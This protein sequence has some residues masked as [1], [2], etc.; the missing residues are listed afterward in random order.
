MSAISPSNEAEIYEVPAAI[1]R[2]ADSPTATESTAG[3]TAGGAASGNLD[4]GAE[5]K[6]ALSEATEH[7][8]GLVPP[9][10]TLRNFVAVNPYLG[11]TQ[12][13]FGEAAS[14]FDRVKHA[15]SLLPLA[16]YL[17]LYEEGRIQELDLNEAMKAGAVALRRPE[18]ETFKADALRER[19]FEGGPAVDRVFTYSELIDRKEG[20]EWS[21]VIIDEI[22]KWCSGRFD[23]GQT[24]WQQPHMQDPIY[25]AWRALA[26]IDGNP[27]VRGLQNF[28]EI[29]RTLPRDA[30]SCIEQITHEIGVPTA[31]LGDYLA[32]SLAS[33]SGWA[34]HLQYRIRQAGMDGRETD[35]CL[36]DLLAI[37]LAFDV[38]VYRDQ[39]KSRNAE[40]WAQAQQASLRPVALESTQD[41]IVLSELEIRHLWQLAL[42]AGYRRALIHQVMAPAQSAGTQKAEPLLQ[43]AFCI[44][45]RSEILRRHLEKGSERVRTIGFAG[46]FGLALESVQNDGS[47]GEARCPALLSPGFSV[48]PK[49]DGDLIVARRRR[50]L[51]QYHS[52]VKQLRLS[53]VVAFPFVETIGQFFGLRLISESLGLTRPGPDSRLFPDAKTGGFS[54]AVATEATVGGELG[55]PLPDRINAAVSILTNM[56]LTQDLAPY[57]LLC[58]HGSTT[59]NNPY[60]SAL[61]C[62]A[63]GGYSGDINARAAANLLNDPA[64]RAALPENGLEVPVSTRFL[65][66]LHDTTTDEIVLYDTEGMTAAELST[67]RQELDRASAA[68]RLER[69]ARLGDAD[70]LG[71]EDLV[72]KRSQDWSEVRPEW[73]LAGNAAFIAAPRE[74]TRGMDLKGR[75]FL[76][77]YNADRDPENSV[78]EL[79]LTAPLVVA[80]W[81]NLQYY[82]STVDNEAF[83]SGS[84]TIHNVVGRH[85]VITGNSGDLRGGLPFQSVHDGERF[86]HEPV[87]L[88]ALIEASQTAISGIVENNDGLRELIE[89]DWICLISIDPKGGGCSRLTPTGFQRIEDGHGQNLG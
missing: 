66:G 45:V 82:G 77:D 23:R 44:D 27:E 1:V 55:L 83:G 76:H 30:A 6:S 20:S 84:K 33:I 87:R 47:Q 19:L 32:R 11:A 13:P 8:C 81:I 15:Q 5:R 79:I 18:L 60:G 61:D 59:T 31:D 41:A 52:L 40:S 53:S 88:T 37:R 78:L 49:S 50:R 4:S 38:A 75:S 67:I 57:V 65:A 42:E 26:G 21:A 63:C 28:R 85:G 46:F 86:V 3:Q 70:G 39:S 35:E 80:S 74:R 71:A 14:E 89:N 51:E 2:L 7:A 36:N 54:P 43:A 34:G 62:G 10:W 9:L 17:K 73:G 29:V 68:T 64:V 56:G 69:A 25:V 12:K 58:G 48:P 72:R 24:S 16:D 22:A